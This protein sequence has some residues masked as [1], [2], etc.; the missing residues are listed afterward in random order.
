MSS[1]QYFSEPV[2]EYDMAQGDACKLVGVKV[3]D[4]ILIGKNFDDFFRRLEI[5][6]AGGGVCEVS[7]YGLTATAIQNR[8]FPYIRI[9]DIDDFGNVNI[10]GINL[11]Y[12]L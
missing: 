4:H 9:S 3:L 1:L 6:K 8:G 7:Q 11:I 10:A 5:G 12:L 2:Y